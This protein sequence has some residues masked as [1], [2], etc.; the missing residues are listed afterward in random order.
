MHDIYVITYVKEGSA[1]PNP[2]EIIEDCYGEPEVKGGA[3]I[4]Q[5]PGRKRFIPLHR[6][7]EI[8][9]EFYEEGE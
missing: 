1:L 7:H 9:R 3:F 5:T 2:K 8:H 6:V 4:I